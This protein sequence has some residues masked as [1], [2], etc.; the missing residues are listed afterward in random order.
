MLLAVLRTEGF[1]GGDNQLHG[2]IHPEFSRIDAHII[3]AGRTPVPIGI[4]VV[5]IGTA[6]V[7]FFESGNGPRLP[8][9]CTADRCAGCAVPEARWINTEN[10]SLRPRRM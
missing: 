5:I 6:S 4:E 1:S 9:D 7:G 10:M 8:P 2:A 3:A